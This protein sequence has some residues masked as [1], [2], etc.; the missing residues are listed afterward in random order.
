MQQY[1]ELSSKG[2]RTLGVAYKNIGPQS[3]ISKDDERDMTFLGIIVLYDP[4]KPGV[5]DAVN[6]LDRLGVTLKVITGDN[7]LVA[8]YINREVCMADGGEIGRHMQYD[9]DHRLG[10]EPNE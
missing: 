9:S 8:A 2:F 1:N 3:I 7:R 5:I 10:D 4:P 6:E